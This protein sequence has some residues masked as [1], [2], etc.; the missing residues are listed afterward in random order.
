MFFRA[1]GAVSQTLRCPAFHLYPRPDFRGLWPQS[2]CDAGTGRQGASLIVTVD[3]GTNSVPSITAAKQAGADVVVL[4]HHQVGGDLPEDAVAIVNPNREDDI[5]QQGHL[6]AAG[7]VFLAL[8]QVAKIPAR[9]ARGRGL[10]SFH[11]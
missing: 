11:A 7:V 3:C 8:V 6:C 10:T 4:D 2:R 5:S 9:A 1:D